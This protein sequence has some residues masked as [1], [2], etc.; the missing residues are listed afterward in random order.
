MNTLNTQQ[1]KQTNKKHLKIKT[2]QVNKVNNTA[3]YKISGGEGVTFHAKMGAWCSY[4]REWWAIH[5]WILNAMRWFHLWFHCRY[6]LMQNKDSDRMSW[7]SKQSMNNTTNVDPVRMGDFNCPAQISLCTTL[8]SCG[9][10]QYCC[11]GGT[12]DRDP[13]LLVFVDDGDG[14]ATDESFGSR[15]KI[16]KHL[17]TDVFSKRAASQ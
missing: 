16:S 2:T 14:G 6:G 11:M 13:L 4:F 8:S 15:K 12:G 9:V 7:T 17:I 10:Y 1:L 3:A 5:I